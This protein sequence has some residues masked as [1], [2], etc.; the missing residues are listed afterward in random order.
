MRKREHGREIEKGIRME[1]E[2]QKEHK[3]WE[4]CVAGLSRFAIDM[5][6]HK[7]L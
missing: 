3:K 4:A 6:A 7:W 1:I 2:K 5:N